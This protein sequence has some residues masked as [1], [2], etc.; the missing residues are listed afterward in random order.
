MPIATDGDWITATSVAEGRTW[1]VRF[2]DDLL[3][4]TPEAVPDLFRLSDPVY[5]TANAPGRRAVIIDRTVRSL[6]GSRF[7]GLF[8]RFGIDP[9]WIEADGGEE[10]KNLTQYSELAA[11][12]LALDLDR[13]SQPLILVGGG[14]IT[15]IGGLLAAT[16]Y[17]GMPAVRIPTT[18]LGLCDAGIAAKVGVNHAGVK[19]A[20]GTF[21]PA[22]LALHCLELCATESERHTAAGLAEIAKVALTEDVALWHMLISH[23]REL[24]ERRMQHPVGREVLW[25]AILPML[26]ELAD[27]LREARLWRTMNF[28]HSVSPTFEMAPGSTLSHGEWV[29]IDMALSV[30]LSMQRGNLAPDLGLEILSVLG[31]TLGLP[32]WHP[33]LADPGLLRSALRSTTALRGGRLRL[34]VLLDIAKVEFVDDVDL[35]DL[36]HAATE[37]RS[38]SAELGCSATR[39]EEVIG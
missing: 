8:E 15:D 2:V 19:N 14:T 23:G 13:R 38:H 1:R 6:F 7:A 31:R 25:R 35:G 20:L 3:R 10:S 36:E 34:P 37:L 4:A 9:V 30:V 33:L 11:R 32:L 22:P 17:R 21:A 26:T 18:L 28:G 39:D 5:A 29:G 24:R 27:N 16:L 12:L